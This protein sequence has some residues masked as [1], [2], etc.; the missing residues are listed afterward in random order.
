[1][2]TF[3]LQPIL[4]VVASAVSAPGKQLTVFPTL[5]RRMERSVGRLRTDTKELDAKLERMGAQLYSPSGKVNRLVGRCLGVGTLIDEVVLNILGF[6]H[7]AGRVSF[8]VDIRERLLV[9]G[10]VCPFA[11]RLL[12]LAIQLIQGKLPPE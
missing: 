3:S 12:N 2:G 5:I 11:S 8:L 7:F 1:M 6:R 4:T 9:F 10:C